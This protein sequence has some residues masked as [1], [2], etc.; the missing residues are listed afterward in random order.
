MPYK[1]IDA[2]AHMCE[3]PNLWVERI[4]RP[5]RERAPRVVKDLNG[6]KG[7]FFVCENLPPMRVAGAFAAGQTFDKKLLEAGIEEALPGGWDPAERLKDMARDGVA[8]AVL[9]KWCFGGGRS[10]PCWV[11]SKRR[12]SLPIATQGLL[13]AQLP[14]SHGRSVLVHLFSR[15]WPSARSSRRVHRLHA[16]LE[17][18]GRT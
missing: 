17:F 9:G 6:R 11:S 15:S 14:L 16:A 10:H 7:S 5:F 18:F 3:L 2:D 4:D 13:A 8:A 1:I 12:H